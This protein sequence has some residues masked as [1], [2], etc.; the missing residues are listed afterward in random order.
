MWDFVRSLLGDVS[1]NE[2]VLVAVIFATVLLFSW[3]PRIGA[4]VGGL[5]DSDDGPPG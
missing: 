1:A 5:F 2:L 3:A 4:A